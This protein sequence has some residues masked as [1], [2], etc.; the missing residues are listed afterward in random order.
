MSEHSA[1]DNIPVI[2]FTLPAAQSLAD[3][4]DCPVIEA[5]KVVVLSHIL[6]ELATLAQTA[7]A[8]ARRQGALPW[9]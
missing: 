6:D 8:T 1:M 4:L 3:E 5:M 9:N 7:E 2:E